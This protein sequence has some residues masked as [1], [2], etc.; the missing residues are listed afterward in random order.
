MS[1]GVLSIAHHAPLLCVETYL[2]GLKTKGEISLHLRGQFMGDE[3]VRIEFLRRTRL[4]KSSLKSR[5]LP[6]RIILPYLLIISCLLLKVMKST[7]SN[8]SHSK[9]PKI[10]TFYLSKLAH[11]AANPLTLQTRKPKQPKLIL[12]SRPQVFLS[13]YLTQTVS[14]TDGPSDLTPS[15]AGFKTTMDHRRDQ[16][17]PQFDSREE[18]SFS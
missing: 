1:E 8:S 3:F 11:T 16:D 10:P 13:K 15:T 2:C 17:M 14:S 9:R 4:I 6:S 5:C 7:R 12:K 18:F